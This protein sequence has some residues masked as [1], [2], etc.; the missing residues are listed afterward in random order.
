M[1]SEIFTLTKNP[2]RQNVKLEGG[3]PFILHSDFKPAGDQP[4]AIEELTRNIVEGETN[5]VLLGATGTGKTFTMVK[6]IETLQRP[7]IVIAPN[8]TLA[9]QLYGEFKSFFPENSVE[10]FVS[11]YDYYQPEAYVPRTDTYVEKEAQIN[12]HIDRMRHS[13]T[14]A[15][16]EKDDVVIVASVSCIYGIGSFESYSD[17]SLDLI[18]G[19]EYDQRKVIN[20]LVEQQYR[21]ND[22][23]FQRGCFRVRGDI[24]EIWPAHYEDRAWRLSFFGDEVETVQEFDPLTGEVFDNLD[25][26]RVYANSHYVT[27]RPTI[28]QAIE[29]IKVELRHR[30][31]HLTE[32]G[33]LLEAQRLEQRTN[34][35]LEMLT[36]AGVC[37]GI[38][39]Y[40]RYLT[41]RNPGEPPPTLLEYLPEKAIMFIDESHVTV[42]QLGGMYKG[43]YRRKSTLSEH[44]FRLPSCIDNRPLKFEEWE[45][46]RPQTV[47]VSA[48]PGDWE[49]QKTEGVVVEQIV[50]PTGLL[51][52]EIVVR[53]V[54][55]QVDELLEEIRVV[56]QKGYRVLV[57]T[58]TKRM[59][60]D[61]TEYLH[62]QGIR[63]RYLHSDVET[64]ERIE[65]IR[66][67]RLGTFDVLVGINLLREGLDIPECGLVA[68]LDADKEGFLRSERSLI[69]T[70]GRASRNAEG[71]VIMFADKIT[72]S[73]E[74][75]I[76]ETE[77][78][79][80]KQK[81]YNEEHGIVAQTVQKNIS[82]AFAGVYSSDIDANRITA[83]LETHKIGANL[84]AH[85]DDLRKQMYK[86]A[87]NLEF[88][89]AARIRDEI[90]RLETVELVLADDPLARQSKVE[91]MV[92]E[93]L[94]ARGRSKLGKPGTRKFKSPLK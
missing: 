62:E 81:K 77:R 73:M 14:R 45:S 87:E 90:K 70:V 42:S 16:L 41:G 26:I 93:A 9:A 55:H 21:R 63:V 38:E 18:A 51:D 85:L 72:R 91:E 50:R 11:Y 27:P 78:R 59:A 3:K 24:V 43:D 25:Q 32:A 10:Y 17:M 19:H 53:P 8:K 60:E 40:S 79:R 13:A 15:L 94:E 30:L 7:A 71:K 83:D 20:N 22:T 52:P 5:Q 39:N 1:T 65:I 29:N 76:S 37:K 88:E 33:R 6:V 89:D 54:T 64:L 48:T 75:A 12:E 57:T 58:L 4:Q 36:A 44:G 68:I 34:F 82:D 46:Y 23:F 92:S 80:E 86:A 28:L 84:Q 56:T 49:L 47:F 66:D 2:Y 35:D 67:L 74:A 61:L 69:Q 31:A